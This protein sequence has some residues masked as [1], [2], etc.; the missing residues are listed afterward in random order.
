MDKSEM[1]EKSPIKD[2]IDKLDVIQPQVVSLQR[3]AKRGKWLI[4]KIYSSPVFSIAEKKETGSIAHSIM[5]YGKAGLSVEEAIDE[6]M[7]KEGVL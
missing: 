2:T 3:E 5:F 4:S 7:R 6:L 1:L